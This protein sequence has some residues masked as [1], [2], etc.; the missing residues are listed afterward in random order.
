MRLI[1]KKGDRYTFLCKSWNFL[2]FFLLNLVVVLLVAFYMF[3][4]ALNLCERMIAYIKYSFSYMLPEGETT[5]LSVLFHSHSFIRLGVSFLAF[6]RCA[7]P[8]PCTNAYLFP[9]LHFQNV[10]KILLCYWFSCSVGGFFQRHFGTEVLAP[11]LFYMLFCKS[12]LYAF[13]RS[14]IWFLLWVDHATRQ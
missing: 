7:F 8:C 6:L 9:L 11:C 2:L 13:K 4:V 1:H 5:F 14:F 12:S 3:I 10:L